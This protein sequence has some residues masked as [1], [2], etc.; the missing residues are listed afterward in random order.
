[1]YRLSPNNYFTL[2]RYESQ[3]QRIDSLC[4]KFDTC[5]RFCFA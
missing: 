4:Q 2:T 5:F 1:M 3:R